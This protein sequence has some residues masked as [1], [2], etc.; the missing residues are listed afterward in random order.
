QDAVGLRA[1]Q[2]PR[3]EVDALLFT[4]RHARVLPADAPGAPAPGATGHLHLSVT[5]VE[6]SVQ[7]DRVGPP[8]TASPH[9]P[10]SPSAPSTTIVKRGG[11][12]GGVMGKLP[13]LPVTLTVSR[14]GFD[15]ARRTEI[16]VTPW[17]PARFRYCHPLP[18]V[19]Q[20]APKPAR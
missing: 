2:V 19:F 3:P 11:T 1:P 10:C 13:F 16:L 9:C 15:P 17:R 5:R 14:P 20:P 12:W 18:V 8:N 4:R 7:L 6:E